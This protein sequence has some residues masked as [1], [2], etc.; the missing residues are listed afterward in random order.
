M[1]LN[2]RKYERTDPLQR[3]FANVYSGFGIFE[4]GNDAVCK[5]IEALRATSRQQSA[6]LGRMISDHNIYTYNNVLQIAINEWEYWFG[7][8]TKSETTEMKEEEEDEEES[9]KK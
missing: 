9:P 6:A 4:R 8:G 5:R 1:T 3:N 2:K 7:A